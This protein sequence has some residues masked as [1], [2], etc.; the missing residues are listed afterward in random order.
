MLLIFAPG[1]KEYDFS[2]G[3]RASAVPHLAKIIAPADVEKN[4][5]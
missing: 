3:K 4:P 1:L 5:P 2:Q